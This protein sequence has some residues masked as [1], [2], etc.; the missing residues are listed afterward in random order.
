MIYLSNDPYPQE[1]SIPRSFGVIV[2]RRTEYL[3][4]DD[5][6]TDLETD[7]DREVLAASQG[8]RLKEMVDGK[9]DASDVYTKTE[10]DEA[11]EDKADKA[12]TYT[13][14]QVDTALAGKQDKI[15]DLQ[16]IRDG[17]A[18]GA[19]AYQKPQTGIPASDLA[20][21]VIPTIPVEDVR[22]GGT[23]VVNNKV[24]EIPAIPDAVEANPTIPAGVTPVDLQ[25]LKVGDDFFSIPQGGGGVPEIFW[26]K[27][28]VTT[29]AD[30]AEAIDAGKICFINHSNNRV[31]I[32]TRQDGG[33]YY[34]VSSSDAAQTYISVNKTNSAYSTGTFY[35]QNTN[36]KSQSVPTDRTSTTKY[37]S[38][39]AVFDSLGKWGVISQTQTWT[40]D[41]NTGYDYTMSNLVWGLIP[42]ANI[43][44]Y[45][46]AGAVFNENTGYFELNGLTDIS[47]NEM[48]KIYTWY[49]QITGRN[50]E[51]TYVFFN[52]R[53]NLLP[54]WARLADRE[55]SNQLS[56]TSATNMFCYAWDCEI[57]ALLSPEKAGPISFSSVSSFL[58]GAHKIRKIVGVFTITTGTGDN[59]FGAS[60][61]EDLRFKQ[62]KNSISF[63]YSPRLNLV[64]VV[65]MVDNAT[66]T[67]V[68]TITLHATAYARCQADTTEY[69]YQGNTYTGILAYASAR[70]ITIASA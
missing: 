59:A 44:L 15:N 29:A 33:Y 13:K 38:V 51:K 35:L 22:V 26:A 9:A 25:N 62:L 21:G 63:K 24:A 67:N 19:T 2:P 28:G 70:N 55:F 6:A 45:V 37:P 36:Q 46:S 65:Y 64:S 10:V 39:K 60:S 52:G 12:D 48:N 43:D 68:I 11:L 53:T 42:K 30:I 58:F 66:N 1:I 61:L 17:A 69:T 7:T 41:A 3:T 27:Y 57:A 23:S 49:C 32:Y 16:T 8:V 5:I 47:Y 14:Q 50:Y 18:A 4:R 40:G 31:Y 54:Q 34:F 56:G 20:D